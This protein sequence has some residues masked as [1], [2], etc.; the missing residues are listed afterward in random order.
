M[1]KAKAHLGTQVVHG[2]GTTTASTLIIQTG[3]IDR[4][5][6][7]PGSGITSIAPLHAAALKWLIHGLKGLEQATKLIK[8]VRGK[9]CGDHDHGNTDDDLQ[10]PRYRGKGAG[11]MPRHFS[12]TVQLK[13][14]RHGK[15]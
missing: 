10:D 8:Y 15:E 6:R 13:V 11:E 1:W 5:Y 3:W 9:P 14:V 4:T 12:W 2:K 7:A